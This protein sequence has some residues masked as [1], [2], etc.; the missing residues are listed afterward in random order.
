MGRDERRDSA[1]PADVEVTEQVSLL[2]RV[3]EWV[4]IDGS[5]PLLTAGL[6]LL[7]LGS[8]LGLH[9]VG[10]VAFEDDDS[11]TRLA[12]GM[13]AGSFSLVTLVVSINQ[14][15]LSREFT[16]TSGFEDRIGS[17]MEF[18]YDVEEHTGASTSPAEPSELLRLLAASIYRITDRLGETV[19]DHDDEEVRSLVGQYTTSVKDNAT[20]LESILGA[21]EFDRFRSISAAMDYEDAWQLYTAKHLR[22]SYEESLPEEAIDAL[23]ELIEI[24]ELFNVARNYFKSTYMQRELTKFSRQTIYS[25]LL[26]VASAMTIGLLFAD[27]GGPTVDPELVP[28]VVSVLVTVVLSPLALLA[29]YILRTA[30]VARRTALTG[31]ILP[32]KGPEES[33]FEVS[34]RDRK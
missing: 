18:Q 7:F 17:V 5:R 8:L 9:R 32:E 4:L 2:E 31:P 14:L 27:V 16:G 3:Q 23:E 13:V 6:L 22:N 30:T 10:I 15:I 19:A 11:M 28:S 21:T 26:A 25:G 20:R 33:P 34:R 24:L 29:A 12:G 1:D